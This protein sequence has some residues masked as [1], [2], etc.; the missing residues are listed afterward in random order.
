MGV[1]FSWMCRTDD[2]VDEHNSVDNNIYIDWSNT[3]YNWSIDDKEID[4]LFTDEFIS[5]KKNYK[6]NY[7]NY[8]M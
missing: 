3:P 4:K 8:E 1:L 6:K 2:A 7:E 5:Y